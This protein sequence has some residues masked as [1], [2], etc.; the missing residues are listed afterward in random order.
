VQYHPIQYGLPLTNSLCVFFWTCLCGKND[1]FRDHH[2]CACKVESQDSDAR[3]H[4]QSFRITDTKRK[5]DVEVQVQ[6][7]S[8][9][10]T[11]SLS[12][13]MLK[14]HMQSFRITDTKRKL[15]VEVQ[16]QHGSSLATVSLSIEMLK[17][18]IQSFSITD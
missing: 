10:S 16:V 7:G 12:V 13:E 4:M 5:L 15:D 6:H 8:S 14:S 9:L 18:H 11:V 17:S 1:F 3:G 2:S